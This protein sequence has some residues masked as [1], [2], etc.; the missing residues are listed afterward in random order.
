M[1]NRERW[2]TEN[3]RE[4][5]TIENRERWRTENNGERKTVE[6]RVTVVTIAVAETPLAARELRY[7]GA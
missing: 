6:T 7:V 3:N 1:E 5:R 4:Q 2:R